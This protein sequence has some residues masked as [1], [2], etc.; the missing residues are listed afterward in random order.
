MSR[1]KKPP[2][3]TSPATR[4]ING[5]FFRAIRQGL[6]NVLAAQDSF[7][8]RIRDHGEILLRTGEEFGDGGLQA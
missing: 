3:M 5:F 6:N 8:M 2:S 7:Y 1:T 4:S